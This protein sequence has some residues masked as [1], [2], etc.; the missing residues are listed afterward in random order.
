MTDTAATPTT[1]LR[2]EISGMTCTSCSTAVT[3]ALTALAGVRSAAVDHE[4]GTAVVAL[5]P[6]TNAE[7]FAF[8]ADAAVH[9]AGYTL[10][11]ASLLLAGASA[12]ADASEKAGG[13]CGG[14]C[15]R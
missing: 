1:T 11:A 5:E 14:G 15:C 4:V 2:L 7:D 12:T 10:E 3:G 8:A 6:G 13:C 9:D